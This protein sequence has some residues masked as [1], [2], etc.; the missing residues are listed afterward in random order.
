[1]PVCYVFF[2]LRKSQMNVRIMDYSIGGGHIIY[3]GMALVL[4]SGIPG[5]FARDLHAERFWD[6]CFVSL[7]P[8]ARSVK[9]RRNCAPA[10]E[11][12]FGQLGVVH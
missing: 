1:M 9:C 7:S 10:L 5:N 6:N 3:G 8:K 11:R 2:N 4:L 12:N